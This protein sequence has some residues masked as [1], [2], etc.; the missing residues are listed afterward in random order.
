MTINEIYSAKEIL[1][2][3]IQD[4]IAEFMM[5]TQVRCAGVTIKTTQF[6]GKETITSV[7]VLIK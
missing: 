3:E 4:L 6:N 1:E 7:Q 2:G 5:E